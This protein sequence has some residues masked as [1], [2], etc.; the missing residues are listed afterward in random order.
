MLKTFQRID[1]KFAPTLPRHHT[2]VL[3][4][5]AK[6]WGTPD[7][8]R[9]VRISYSQRLRRSLGR[10]RPKSG[11]ITLH[12][13]LAT[14]PHSILLEV[15]CHELAH[16][17]AYN[18]HGSRAKPHGP[19]WR[20]LVRV[21]GYSPKTRL[22]CPGLPVKTVTPRTRVPR[23]S[24][25]CPECGTVYYLRRISNRDHCGVCLD[26]GMKVN[27]HTSSVT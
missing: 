4:R 23:K 14:A 20:D 1:V 3:K 12:A 13:W 18:I 21:A 26:R 16:V 5:W 22:E 19:E 2:Q 9:Q 24:C 8:V 17:A 7:I 27:L 11:I 6:C 15:L 10:V 25:R